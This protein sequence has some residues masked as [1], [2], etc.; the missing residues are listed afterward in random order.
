MANPRTMTTTAHGRSPAER[1]A[2]KA[3]LLKG[4][5]ERGLELEDVSRL[6]DFHRLRYGSSIS[7]VRPEV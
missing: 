5:Y 1:R 4:Q 3:R 7:A 2:W 6:V